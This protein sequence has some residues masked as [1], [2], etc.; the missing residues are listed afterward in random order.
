MGITTA[1]VGSVLTAGA[2]VYSANKAA[3]SQK[4]ALKYQKEQEAKAVATKT[5]EKKLPRAPVGGF[6]P[7]NIGAPGGS[8]GGALSGVLLGSGTPGAYAAPSSTTLL[9][10]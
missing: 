10:G 3:K 8:T 1:I 7:A 2:S 4:E 6:D 5:Q 9:G